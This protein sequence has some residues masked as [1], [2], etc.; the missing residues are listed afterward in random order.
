[1]KKMIDQMQLFS[2]LNQINYFVL[3]LNSH[4]RIIKELLKLKLKKLVKKVKKA[5]LMQLKNIL[6]M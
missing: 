2:F 4:L 3:T 6:L 5:F 1:M